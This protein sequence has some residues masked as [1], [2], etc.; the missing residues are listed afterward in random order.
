MVTRAAAGGY[1]SSCAAGYV[2][3]DVTS[4][5]RAVA[6]N[7]SGTAGFGLRASSETDIASQ[8]RFNSANAFSN[9]PFLTV[10]YNRLPS[11]AQLPSVSPA[12]T[13]SGV[14][15][16]GS[17]KPLLSSSAFD[18]DGND[19]T[20]SFKTYASATSTTA[21]ATLCSVTVASGVEGSCRPTAGLVD[22]QTYSVRV[23]ANDGRLNAT[24]LSPA[25]SFKI[26]AT[27]PTA[28]VISC[29][30]VNGYQGGAIPSTSFTCTVSTP[31]VAVSLRPARVSISLDGTAPVTYSANADG[32]FSK[33]V[34]I[35]AGA[36][37]RKI[38]A[39]S[40]SATGIESAT[41]SH[42]MSFGAV[43]VISPLTVSTVASNFVVSGYGASQSG[44]LPTSATIEWR[45]Q[46]T[47]GL[48]NV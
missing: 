46:D 1:S 22:G 37:Q 20:L 44:L 35:P 16:V 29:P 30:Y 17:S 45:K 32:S 40:E 2:N 42:T 12:N 33:T 24:G 7:V 21:L 4:L 41:I 6:P 47:T 48:W 14:L 43:G 36:Y 26:S 9:K 18:P 19:V 38:T 5:V 34:S 13:V 15:T 10:T 39:V 27:I 23:T 11:A 28:P 25:V 8:K 3:T 31:A